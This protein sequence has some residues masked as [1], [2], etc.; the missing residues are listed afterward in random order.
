MEC[1]SCKKTL[2]INYDFGRQ[3]LCPGCRRPTRVCKN[4]CHYDPSRYN[5][6]TE[7]IADRIVDK[8][9]ANFCDY[10]KA[11]VNTLS[12]KAGQDP[13][14]AALAAAEALFKKK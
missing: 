2:D 13:R 5:E 8:E 12:G 11:G 7:T 3:E 6:C 14:S 1:W 10:F 4:C 9:T